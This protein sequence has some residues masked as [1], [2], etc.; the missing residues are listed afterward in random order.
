[1]RGG[2]GSQ[3]WMSYTGQDM[4][5]ASLGEDGVVI[6]PERAPAS[7]RLVPTEST[8]TAKLRPLPSDQLVT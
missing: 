2:R 6:C 1:M 4:P 8:R 7:K 5:N 3:Y